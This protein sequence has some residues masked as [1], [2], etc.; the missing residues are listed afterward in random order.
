MVRKKKQTKP[1]IADKVDKYELYEESVQ[2]AEAEIDFIEEQFLKLR[3]RHARSLREDF[4]GTASVCKEWINRDNKNYAVGV[5]IDQNVLDWGNKKHFSNLS[6]RKKSRIKLSSFSEK[7]PKHHYK[8]S[9]VVD[10]GNTYH[11][12]R[13]DNNVRYSHKQGTL[14]V[15][16]IDSDG[17]PIYE[18]GRA[19]V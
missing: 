6:Q 3:G 1:T 7:C 16:N 14:R 17:K 18:I 2:C 12:Y 13:Q 5:D 8:G 4:C 15:E 11:F 19:H 9:L 10:P